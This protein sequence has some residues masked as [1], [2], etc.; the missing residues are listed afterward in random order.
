MLR[1]NFVVTLSKILSNPDMYINFT[2]MSQNLYCR[3]AACFKLANIHPLC[4]DSLVIGSADRAEG[5]Q[6]VPQLFIMPWRSSYN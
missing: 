1:I 3:T 6:A 4:G 2:A 5:L